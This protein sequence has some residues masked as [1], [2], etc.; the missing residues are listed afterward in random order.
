MTLSVPYV[1]EC[2]IVRS[3]GGGNGCGSNGRY[4]NINNARS[5]LREDN[6]DNDKAEEE[7]SGKQFP[8]LCGIYCMMLTGTHCMPLCMTRE[9][10]RE[11]EREI[12]RERERE[13]ERDREKERERERERER[14]QYILRPTFI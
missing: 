10:E 5:D 2:L 7:E 8:P 13:R 4:H 12:A 1:P 9:R 3:S 14:K 6:G 11:R